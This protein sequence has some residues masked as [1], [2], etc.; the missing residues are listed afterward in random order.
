MLRLIRLLCLCVTV[1]VFGFNGALHATTVGRTAGSFAVSGT[2]AATYSIPIWAPPGPK[3]MQ[4]S[5]ALVYSSQSGNGYV[6]VGWNLAGLSSIYR[7]N[8]T[9]AQ[10]S[11]PAPVALSTSD[12]YCLDGQRLRLTSGTYG[13]A[14]ST[15]QTEI[16]N[17]KN[18]TAYGTAGNGPSYFIVQGPDGRSFQYGNGGNSQVLASGTSTALTWMLDQVSD[19]PGNTMTISYSTATGSV[20][21][22]V[23][24]WTPTS[25]GSSSYA[26]AM[27]FGYGTN[28]LPAAGYVAGTPVQNPNLLSSITIAYG[29]TQVKEYVLTYT[30]S[31]TTGRETLTQVQECAAS[32]S[33]CLYPTTITYQSGSAGVSASATTV[34]SGS[35]Y[36]VIQ[37]YDLNGDGYADLVYSNGTSWYVAFGSAS[38]YGTPVN[39]GLSA[40][41]FP[42]FGDLLGTGQDGILAKNGS[43][44]YYYT[45]NGSSFVGTSTGLAF[46]TTALQFALA[47]ING[48][49]LP[50]L[51]ALYS[52]GSVTTRLN[53]SSSTTPSFASTVVTTVIGS[54][55]MSVGLLSPDSQSENTRFFDFN[56]DGRQDLAVWQYYCGYYYM[57]SCMVPVYVIDELIS[58]TGGTF[59]LTNIYTNSAPITGSVAFANLNNDA[60]TD[61]FLYG[62]YGNS[63]YISPCNGGAPATL[64]ATYPIVAVMDWNGDGLA[65]LIENNGGTLYVQ[66]ATATGYGAATSTSLAYGATCTY[67]TLDANGDGLDDLGCTSG[68]FKYY[69]HNGAGTPPDLVS[70]TTDG[71]GN[72]FNPTYH[73]M[74]T[75]QCY[76]RDSAPPPYPT[77]AF[78]SPIYL[79]CSYTA[80]DGTGGSYSVPYSYYDADK[81]LQGRGW[82][83]FERIYSQDSRNGIVNTK[84]YSTVFPNAGMLTMN[85]DRQSDWTTYIR[86][87]INTPASLAQETLASTSFQQRYFPWLTQ[88]QAKMYEFGGSKN[89]QL[90]TTSTTTYGT[91]DSYGNFPTVAVAVQDNDST[92]A[93]YGDTW[94][95]TTTN[96]TDV[97][98]SP[99]CLN[100]FTQIQVAY[101]ASVGSAVTRTKQFSPDLVNCRYT[102]LV[103][104]PTS[105][106]YKVIEALGYDSFGNV[107]SDSVTGISMTGRT[108]SANWGTTGQFPM[109]VTDPTGAQ[110]QLNYNFSYGKVS[111]ITDPNN[112]TTS[113]QY[114]D[115]FG[116]ETQETRPDG[117]YT[118]W[119]Y[120]DDTSYG[121]GFHGITLAQDLYGSGGTLVRADYSVHDQIG[122][123]I[124]K[125]R[126]NQGATFDQLNVKYD[127]LGRTSQTSFPCTYTGGYL[128]TPCTYWTTTSYDALNRV[129]Q[130]QRPISSSNSTLQT[131]SY[132]YAGRTS[133]TTDANGNA[134]TLVNDVNG[135]LRKTQDATGYAVLL[136]YDAVGNKTSTTDSLGNSL[137]SGTYQYPAAQYLIGYTDTDF[138]TWSFT[139]DALGEIVGW[140]DAKGQ[141]FSAAYDVLGRM[142]SRSEPDL[143]SSWTWGTSAAAHEIGQLHSVCTGTG[144]SPTACNSAGYAEAETYDGDGR[145]A[146]R[147]IVIPGDGTY[148]YG[149]S[150]NSTTGLLDTMTYP[151][152]NPTGSSPYSLQVQYGY[153]Y[154][155]LSTLT[156]ISD[157][158]HVTL[159]TANTE[160]PNGQATQETLGNG[161]VVNHSLDAV[162]GWPSAITAGVGGGAGLQNNSYLFDYVGNLTQRQDNNA[163]TTEN[164]YPDALNRLTHTVGDSNFVR[165]YDAMGRIASWSA[166]GS[167]TNNE[168]YSTPQSGC[169][170]YA[171]AQLHAVRNNTQG[172]WSTSYCYDANG[173]TLAQSPGSTFT[174]TS[175][176]QLSTGSWSGGSSQ[177]FYDENHQRWKQLAVSGGVSET[178]TYIGGLLEKMTNSSGTAYRHYVTAGN[179]SIVYARW[180]TGSNFTYYM[181]Q[182]HLGSSAVVTDQTG[183]LVVGEKFAAFGFNENTTAQKAAISTVSRHE[184]TGQEDLPSLYLTNMNGRIYQSGGL[185]TFLSPDPKIPDPTNT[186][187]Y[188]R[189]SY[190]DNSPLTLVDP[191]GFDAMY[192]APACTIGSDFCPGGNSC[193]GSCPPG[194]PDEFAYFT[195]SVS[196]CEPGQNC[197]IGTDSAGF[198]NYTAS[199]ATYVG[200]QLQQQAATSVAPAAQ[201]VPDQAAQPGPADT[202]A[203]G[204]SQQSQDGLQEVV[205][206]GNCGYHD[207]L[208]SFP[209]CVCSAA[210]GFNTFRS[211]SAPGAP[212]AQDGPHNVMLAGHNPILQIVDPNA[213][214]ITNIA[215]DGHEFGGK[216]AISFS[217]SNGV[218]NVNI[219]GNGYGPHAELDQIFGPQIFTGLAIAAFLYLNPPQ[220]FKSPL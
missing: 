137:W 129:T 165:G 45:W 3:G 164:A 77:A 214:T 204:S 115:G 91:P 2:G 205:V 215:L 51:V 192:S 87:V 79:A 112:L 88:A 36:N 166:F 134:K 170:Y 195:G 95:T 153:Q 8:L 109:G 172:P 6:G 55:E 46:D 141:T 143:Y 161:V 16:A 167:T 126:E 62:G 85:L 175:Y 12:G 119:S 39:T 93:Y 20:V 140:S 66:L 57:G 135:W 44:W 218:T 123:V 120:N 5:M 31:S 220:N 60:C 182:D 23:I 101:T 139:P 136:G 84:A 151:T 210:V 92:S 102:Q 90:I 194:D 64:T 105:S 63:V 22:N 96:T 196:L 145:L 206:C 103:T 179:N 47:D 104:E 70:S 158:P 26:Y 202:S 163:G 130:I 156:N 27:T 68:G 187:D 160:N 48:D 185:G 30:Q 73:P 18:V 65:D 183:S 49:G 125:L 69:P 106:T 37:R 131:T 38:G 217:T 78:L 17:F 75:G 114:T 74:S 116:R 33:N 59:S 50:D 81:N 128:T 177:F 146:D 171:N 122:R 180:S 40:S 168:D 189:Y 169:T 94:T 42:L 21:P 186:Q 127:S 100:L 144:T 191:T 52:V 211:F 13:T 162:T 181:T 201:P 80:S 176:N 1:C 25:H 29:G 72:Y 124:D 178:T 56:G 108:V 43:T 197:G 54:N 149:Y 98:T 199:E 15:Y 188:G 155:V 157:S 133:T 203:Q 184:F 148:T 159:W 89:G 174:W 32:T 142:S 107:N 9:Y 35:T 86:D 152:V 19:P 67:V 117:T 118:T 207:Y 212:Y 28:V 216:V 11:A 190:V 147:S 198:T 76:Y 213:M 121:F 200:S 7:C 193:G 61:A 110:T 97:S 24:S 219:A 113:R 82:Q 58:Q 4:P 132:T 53:T 34:T 150:Y 154:G 138:G 10:D 14:G 99:W 71:Y 83:G 173:N 208:V 209:L 111:S 41:Y